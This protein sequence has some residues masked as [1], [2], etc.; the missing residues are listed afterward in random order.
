MKKISIILTTLLMATSSY[1][2]ADDVTCEDIIE[3]DYSLVPVAIGYIV[4]WNDNEND[5]ELIELDTLVPVEVDTIIEVCKAN[6]K[7]KVKDVINP[8]KK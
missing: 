7:K 4:G 8:P 3:M 5:L 2:N 1:A 6:P